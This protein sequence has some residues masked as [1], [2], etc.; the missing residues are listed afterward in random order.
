MVCEDYDLVAL[1]E[2]LRD[3]QYLRLKSIR[4]FEEEGEKILNELVSEEERLAPQDIDY[5]MM[6][7]L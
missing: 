4:S 2:L 1:K 3:N 6:T 5:T 7:E